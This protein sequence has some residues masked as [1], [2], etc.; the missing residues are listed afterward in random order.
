MDR[1]FFSLVAKIH[2][3]AWDAIIPR[4][5]GAGRR[6]G[7]EV[8]LNPQPLPPRD[9]EVGARL[10]ADLLDRAIIVVGGREDV[11][12]RFLADVEDWCGTGWPRWFPKPPPPP[13][14]RDEREVFTG[15]ALQAAV[16]AGQFEHH[17][18]LQEA[19]LAAAEQLASAG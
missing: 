16:L 18:E 19:L 6:F 14:G 4:Y 15:A 11:T 17:P 3:E 1:E 12:G 8:A 13:W 2:P 10:L 7:D 9:P 5:V